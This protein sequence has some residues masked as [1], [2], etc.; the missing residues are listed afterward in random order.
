MIQESKIIIRVVENG[1][2]YEGNSGTA[3]FEADESSDVDALVNLLWHLRSWITDDSKY[4]RNWITDNSKYARNR[5]TI[6]QEI[7][8]KYEVKEDEVLVES[9]YYR[10]RHKGEELEYGETIVKEE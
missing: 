1:Y 2:I 3:V 8:E 6:I 5:V 4:T 9:K 10:V 7:G